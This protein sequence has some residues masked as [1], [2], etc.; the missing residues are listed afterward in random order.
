MRILFFN[1]EFPPLGGGAA[2]ANESLFTLFQ[3]YEDLEIDLITS[4]TESRT[5]EEQFSDRIR[6]VRLN[7]GK[8]PGTLHSQSQRELLSYTRAARR[9]SKQLLQE[10]SYILSHAFFTV[11]CGYLAKRTGLPYLVSLRGADVPGYAERFAALYYPL[12]PLVRSI[13]KHADAVVSNSDGLRQLALQTLSSQKIG[14]IPNGVYT[15]VFSPGTL[16]VRSSSDPFQVLTVSRLTQRKDIVS[17]IQAIKELRLK[18]EPVRALIVG[19]GEQREEL[20]QL[21]R[22]LGIEDSITFAGRLTGSD[23]IH[24]YQTSHAFCLPSLN[25]GMSNTVLEALACGLPLILTD[26]GGTRELAG[27]TALIIPKQDP[28]A[29][30]SAISTF[31]HDSSLQQAAAQESRERAQLFRWEEVARHYY[32]LYKRI[33]ETKKSS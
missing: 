8:R 1:Y 18:H 4:N 23:L 17:L 30:A 13:W 16:P 14:I 12:R 10:H 33:E 15:D 5:V 28:T 20:E 31:L 21:S 22:D 3:E 25:E 32:E 9:Y 29:I 27:D 11:P 7:I 2:R 6:I 24:A 26:T 19:D